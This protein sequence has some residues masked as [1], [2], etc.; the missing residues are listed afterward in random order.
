M[1]TAGTGFVPPAGFDWLPVAGAVAGVAPEPEER[2]VDSRP[3]GFLRYP[4]GEDGYRGGLVAGQHDVQT[5]R[6]AEGP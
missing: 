2:R 6:E 3:C 1:V 5:N 4:G